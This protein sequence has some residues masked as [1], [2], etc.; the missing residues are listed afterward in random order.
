ADVD[1]FVYGDTRTGVEF[2]NKICADMNEYIDKNPS[3]QTLALH[4]G[5]FVTYGSRESSWSK[6]WFSTDAADVHKFMADVPLLSCVGNHEESG[7]LFDKYFPYPFVAKDGRYW[8]FDYG[9]AHIV[10]L[11]QYSDYSENS[12]QH[13]WLEKELSTTD[14]KWK[15]LVFHEPGWSAGGYHKDNMDVRTNIQPLLVKYDVAAV[16]TGHNHY[17]AR[18]EVEGV[19]HITTGGGGAPLYDP[20]MINKEL[21]VIKKAYHFCTVSINGNTL[22]FKAIDIDN[23]IIDSFTVSK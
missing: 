6:E 9:P 10:F 16:F 4:V 3:F 13:A 15:F 14:K 22:N 7:N 17:Y 18:A 5:D 21:K 19:M 12:P 8:S 11:D 2:H 20:E 1:F 23:K